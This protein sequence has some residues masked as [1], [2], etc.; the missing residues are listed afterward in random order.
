M[1]IYTVKKWCTQTDKGINIATCSEAAELRQCL[2]MVAHPADSA[3]GHVGAEALML[4][5]CCQ[6]QTS[7][8]L[9]PLPCSVK[10]H[11][12]YRPTHLADT[13]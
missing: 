4:Q 2:T 9:I 11:I 10:T 13:L 7:D 8:F 12:T 5:Q 3:G 6:Q 1:C